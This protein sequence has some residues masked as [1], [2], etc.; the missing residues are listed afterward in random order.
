MSNVKP[1]T[2]F[3]TKDELRSLEEKMRQEDENLKVF[4]FF[5]HSFFFKK[6]LEQI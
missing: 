5:F 1:L 6:K 4:S 3:A 2:V